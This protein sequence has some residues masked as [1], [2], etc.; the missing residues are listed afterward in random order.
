MSEET[1]KRGQPEKDSMV[2]DLEWEEEKTFITLP[3]E[4][5]E[6]MDW[7][8]ADEIEISTTENC[9]DWGEVQSI[10]LRNLTIEKQND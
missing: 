7:K 3:S 6:K 4:I 2:V 8:E 9:F 10:V 5:L 1:A